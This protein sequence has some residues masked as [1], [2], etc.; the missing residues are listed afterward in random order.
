[1]SE[2]SLSYTWYTALRPE[3]NDWWRLQNYGSS[4]MRSCSAGPFTSL[5]PRPG[6]LHQRFCTKLNHRAIPT[7]RLFWL[8]LTL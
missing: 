4:P 6:D 8:G 5:N 2:T 3:M 7:L 1:M